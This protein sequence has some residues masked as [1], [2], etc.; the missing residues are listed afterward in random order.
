M[1]DAALDG[2]DAAVVGLGR[3]LG[4]CGLLAGALETCPERCS[5]LPPATRRRRPRSPL[6]VGR[7]RSADCCCTI[8]GCATFATSRLPG[9]TSVISVPVRS[10]PPR[11]HRHR[12]RGFGDVTVEN[13]NRN[14]NRNRDFQRLTE[15]G[16]VP[17]RLATVAWYGAFRPST[18]TQ[19]RCATSERRFLLRGHYLAQSHHE[20]PTNNAY[21]EPHRP[22]PASTGPPWGLTVTGTVLEP[23]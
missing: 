18:P 21:F 2:V 3:S 15:T 23:Q 1:R 10:R 13:R 6:R 11:D 12:N 16:T 20:N 5:I 8:I 4:A 9:S 22:P 7:P 17:E 19:R 14:R